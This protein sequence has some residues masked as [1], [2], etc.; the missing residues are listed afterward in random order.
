M[1]WNGRRNKDDA[2]DLP[3]W[4]VIDWVKDTWSDNWVGRALL[5]LLLLTILSIP[6]TIYYSIVENRQWAEFVATHNCK[7]V[8]V[9]SGDTQTG[10]G[11]GITTSGQMGTVV[12]TSVTPSKVGWF[13]D[14]GITYWR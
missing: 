5:V 2:D 10:I 7:K 13:C 6:A 8:G 3:W 14:D 12:T 9:M 11:F 1:N 4:V